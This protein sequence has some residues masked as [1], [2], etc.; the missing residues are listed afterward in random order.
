MQ[1]RIKCVFVTILAM[2]AVMVMATSKA[3]AT[4]VKVSPSKTMYTINGNTSMYRYKESTGT[5]NN[6]YCLDYCG[7]LNSGSQ[8]SMS[9]DI[10]NLTDSQITEI[11]GNVQN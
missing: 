6:I 8:Y 7:I 4:T 9:S 1:K 11:F 5:Y 10:Y 3:E 2:F